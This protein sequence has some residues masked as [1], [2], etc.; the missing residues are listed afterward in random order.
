MQLN[1]HYVLDVIDDYLPVNARKK[2]TYYFFDHSYCIASESVLY[3]RLKRRMVGIVFVAENKSVIKTFA[4]QK[5]Y[6]HMVK[7]QTH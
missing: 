6:S 1:C 7:S 2:F 4:K 5:V 3:F